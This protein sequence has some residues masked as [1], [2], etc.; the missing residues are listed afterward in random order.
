MRRL[1]TLLLACAVLLLLG[2]ASSLAT[3]ARALSE[4]LLIV[5]NAESRGY[6]DPCP[7]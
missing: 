5:F 6:F 1:R 3:P 2:A 7:S 4:P